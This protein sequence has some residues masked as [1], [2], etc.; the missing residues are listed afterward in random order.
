MYVEVKKISDYKLF[1][2]QSLDLDD[3]N[4]FKEEKDLEIDLLIIVGGDGSILWSLLSFRD[5]APP[6]VVAFG[7]V[8]KIINYLSLGNSWIFVQ[9][10]YKDIQRDYN[11]YH[12]TDFNGTEFKSREKE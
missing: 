10:Q 8:S 11:I 2:P 3:L 9:F 5:R 6:P 1:L 4:I 12:E 7:K